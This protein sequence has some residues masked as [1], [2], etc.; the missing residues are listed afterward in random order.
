MTSMTCGR[1]L[2][3]AVLAAGV[4]LAS[5]CR[6]RPAAASAGASGEF[7][8]AS[9][10]ATA[11]AATRGEVARYRLSGAPVRR[12]AL[13]DE[14]QE[15]SGLALSSDGRL[16]AHGDEEATVFQIDP[17]TG[18]VLERFRLAPTGQEPELGK[19]ARKGRVAGD[20]EDMA[21]VED[22]FFLVTSNG[23]LLEFA[24][25]GDGASVPY[26]AY[27]TGL[28][29][30]CE[31]EGLTYEAGAGEL[32]LL[33]KEFHVKA[34]R[35]RVAAYG[36]SIADRQLDPTPRLAVPYAALRPLIGTN[37]FNGSA[38]A[39]TP[40]GHSVVLVAGPQRLFVEITADGRVVE[41]GPLDR[42]AVEQPEG[43][44]FLRDGAL[45]ISSE[46][47]RGAATLNAYAPR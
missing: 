31:V 28:G 9:A 40:G 4:L 2:A 34:E 16:F 45:L 38:L 23:V 11:G 35:G 29:E 24:E 46:G 10:A 5:S 36:W 39:F 22:R 21:I 1:R 25:G 47:A 18:Q 44:A 27:P 3:R 19:K 37:A 13:P 17:G 7:G 43:I 32:L 15:I 30:R 33:C 20:F 14:L 12:V 8:E 6:E 26:T 42:R 41:G